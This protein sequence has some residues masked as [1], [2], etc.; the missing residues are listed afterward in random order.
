MQTFVTSPRKIFIE[1]EKVNQLRNQA[2]K[3][4]MRELDEQP[5]HGKCLVNLYLM[6]RH[7][8]RIGDRIKNIAEEVIYL[9]EGK[10]IRGATR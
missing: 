1:D 3:D 8:E 9:V 5:G 4:V 10:I 7:L 2:Y 6:A